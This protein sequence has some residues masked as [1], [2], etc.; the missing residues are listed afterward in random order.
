MRAGTKPV[1]PFGWGGRG[2][3][4]GAG[5]FSAGVVEGVAGCARVEDGGEF[6]LGFVVRAFCTALALI[7]GVAGC[8]RVEDGCAVGFGSVVCPPCVG[9]GCTPSARVVDDPSVRDEDGTPPAFRR[10]AVQPHLGDVA[11]D[12]DRAEDTSGNAIRL[13]LQ[14]WRGSGGKSSRTIRGYAGRWRAVNGRGRYDVRGDVPLGELL[15]RTPCI[16]RARDEHG[17]R[18]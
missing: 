1:G 18:N 5:G 6:D 13:R 14:R 17:F 10:G 12:G 4:A 15:A 16:V 3:G 7:E 11:A 8:A 2:F 9:A